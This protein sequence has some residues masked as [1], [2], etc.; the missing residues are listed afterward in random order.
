VGISI[1]KEA[2][3][4]F[5]S[6]LQIDTRSAFPVE[7]AMTQV[8]LGTLLL[9]LGTRIPGAAGRTWFLKSETALN[10]AAEV[11]TR[12]TYPQYWDMIQ[13]KLAMLSEAVKKGT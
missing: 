12:E 1:I 10:S 8:D 3:V 6:A 5:D 13:A 4:A 9:V 11:F 2:L 7:W